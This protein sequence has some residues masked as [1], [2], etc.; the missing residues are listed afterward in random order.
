MNEGLSVLAEVINGFHMGGHLNVYLSNTDLQLTG[1]DDEFSTPHYG[2]AGL[3]TYYFYEHY[4]EEAVRR[5][6][7]NPQNGMASFDAVLRDLGYPMTSID[8]FADWAVANLVNNPRLAQ[9]QYGYRNEVTERAAFQRE[10]SEYPAL[11]QESVAQYGVDYIHL[12]GKGNVHV[13]FRGSSLNRVAPLS[14]HGGKFVM[15]GNRGDDSDS[16]LYTEVDL[17]GVTSATLTFW[18]WYDMEKLWD[19]AYVIVS[20]DGGKHWQMLESPN[21]TRE[22][23]YGNNLGVG[24][25][26]VS[27][28]G[29]TPQWIE[30]HIDLSPYAGQKILVGFE[31]VTD[32]AFTRPGFFVDDVRIEA[33]GLTEGFEQPLTNWV[34][35]GFLRTDTFVPQAYLIQVIQVKGD[36]MKPIQR[37]I[38]AQQ[39]RVEFDVQDIGD[40]DTT[41]AI[42]AFAPLTWETADYTLTIQPTSSSR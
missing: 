41:L 36:K 22:N 7:R 16:R 40:W 42:S 10:V 21:M 32:D 26:G 13:A 15:W 11:I 12:K 4:G 28:G 37:Y 5:L 38:V 31:Y 39:E 18:T 14:P 8:L 30:E 23:P 9:G 17:T 20:T 2:A 3:F 34:Q 24:Y 27:G 35:E 25:T 1:W 19:F 6:A 33:V 29:D